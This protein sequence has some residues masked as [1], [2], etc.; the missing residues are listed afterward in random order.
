MSNLTANQ[1]HVWQY[2]L[3]AWA[4]KKD[5]VWCLQKGKPA[6]FIS[7]TRNV[8]SERFFYEFQELSESD[9]Q[10]LEYIINQSKDES[11][12]KLNRGWVDSLQTPFTLRRML[13][14]FPL[15]DESKA[16]VEKLLDETGKTLGEQYHGTMED[17]GKPMLDS[18]RAGD[19]SFYRNDDQQ[20]MTFIQFI[21]YQYFRTA[22]IRNGYRAIPL[23]L[24]HNRDRTWPVEAF[25]YAT[26][27][28]TSL[29]AQRHEYEI[30]MIDNRTDRPFIT[31]D[32]PVINLL[33][34]SNPEVEL[35]YPLTP[36]RAMI[37]SASRERYPSG[38][39]GAGLL[40]VEGYNFQMYQK[41]D[42]Q[43]YGSDKDYLATFAGLPKGDL[44]G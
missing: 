10:Y 28:G 17:Q 21:S 14:N 42:T 33:G 39:K 5:Q 32:Q 12:R 37:L 38:Q 30:V 2:H 25:I 36:R 4:N 43:L 23:D 22:K 24:P 11:L 40:E 35:F 41:S 18:L 27:L 34:L 7:H 9:E 26:N 44:S 20:Q 6:P 8:G 3:K 15:S 1:H 16:Q 13:A 29:Y 19:S 31:G